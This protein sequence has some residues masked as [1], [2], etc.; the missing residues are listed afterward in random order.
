VCCTSVVSL[1]LKIACEAQANA[2]SAHKAGAP[3]RQRPEPAE[4]PDLSESGT[5]PQPGRHYQH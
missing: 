3:F 5:W 4:A 1:L 2:P